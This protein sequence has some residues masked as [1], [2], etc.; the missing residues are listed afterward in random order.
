MSAKE[1]S[2]K[3][4]Y[5]LV[6]QKP[7]G[8]FPDTVNSWETALTPEHQFAPIK[9]THGTP[10]FRKSFDAKSGE[11]ALITS[12]ALG[13]YE[14]WCNGKRIGV[15]EYDG[16]VVYDEL[17][18][19]WTEYRKRVMSFTYDISDYLKDGNN[20]VLAVAAPGWWNGRISFNQYENNDIAFCAAIQV[21]DR[22]IYTDETWDTMWGGR[23]R[24]ADIWD[25]EICDG[26][27]PSYEEISC[28]GYNTD[29]WKKPTVAD[30][31]NIEI[32]PNIGPAIRIRK[33]LDKEPVSVT[34]YD[35][36]KD[37]GSDYGEI[38][39][40]SRY[41]NED[42]FVLKKGQKAVVDFGQEMVGWPQIRV[43]TEKNATIC[44]RASE[45]LNDSGLKSRG[46]DGAK[47]SVYTI[48][49]RSAKAKA[50]YKANGNDAGEKY[51]PMFTFFGFR[52]FEISS[53]KDI[54][55]MSLKA[56]TVGSD[57]E[58]TGHIETSHKDVN[59][60]ISNIIWGQRSNYLTVPTDCPQRDERLGWTGDTQIFCN[61]AAYNGDVDSF[62][63]QWLTDARDSQNS[64][65]IFPD[66]IPAVRVVGY[67]GAAWAD[68]P[69][70]VC[71]VMWKMY[72]D[73]DIIREN[74]DSLEKYM[75][76]LASRGMEGPGEWYADWLA[77]E[78][79]S[80]KY[81]AKAYYAYDAMLMSELS[82]V[83]GLSDKQ[84]LYGELY[85]AI[86]D[87]FNSNYCDG[88]GMLK[89]EY[90]TQTG[91]LLALKTGMLDGENVDIAVRN[92]AE[93]IKNNGYKL[94]TG[95]VG[96]GTLNQTLSEFGLHNLAYS[97]LLQTDNPSWLYSV[98][99]GATT[100]WERWNSYTLADGFGDVG[101]NSFNHY[102]YGV[103]E[104]WM[105]RYMAGIEADKAHPG[106][107]HVI[108]QPNPDTRGADELPA[109]QENITWVKASFNSRRG[110]I[111]SEWS[112]DGKFTYNTEIPVGATLYL[113]VIGEKHTF[114]MNGEEKS[115]S[116]CK[117]ENGKLVIELAPGKYSFEM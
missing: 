64:D 63:R 19:G 80:G 53:D 22:V 46:N 93:K 109:G 107:E 21:G 85:N 56:L 92:L 65:G 75:S 72:G 79:T 90:R 88:T 73:T 89:E 20:V 60:L 102:A 77:Y 104:E 82:G 33:G 55:V 42:A 78:P 32:T 4:A 87:D 91:Y 44:L 28:A 95:F 5:W 69:I 1:I 14:L 37:N 84:K 70:I 49:Y 105:Y 50:Y 98:H 62:F 112:L 18:P 117:V 10:M 66:V 59:K 116:D 81:I 34:I 11:K 8:L 48:N 2:L 41:D 94:S 13:I 74:Y 71:H 27:I 101:M 26:N 103:V 110:R 76:W 114:T 23:V 108:L 67:G 97:L 39:V 45:M 12:T 86:K 52:Y 57:I 96:T 58:E 111:V 113:P 83:I 99:Q 16:N 31:G 61:T 36:V 7:D 17:K 25:G 51:C 15:K 38:N 29:G 40:V 106:F 47:G 54:E 115:I 3:N 24:A 9:D 30:H 100:I 35:G 43:H 68:A 6:C